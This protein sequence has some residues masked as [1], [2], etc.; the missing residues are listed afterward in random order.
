M[1]ALLLFSVISIS[2]GV[3]TSSASPPQCECV[4]GFYYNPLSNGTWRIVFDDES[5]DGLCWGEEEP[6]PSVFGCYLNFA[7]T[8]TPAPPVLPPPPPSQ[9]VWVVDPTGGGSLQKW[10]EDTAGSGVICDYGQTSDVDCGQFWEWRIGGQIS[11]ETLRILCTSC[12][13]DG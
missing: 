7:W 13:T 3:P 6:C 5:D 12:S 8:W 11:N 10:A 9:Y 1:R 2:S 4:Y